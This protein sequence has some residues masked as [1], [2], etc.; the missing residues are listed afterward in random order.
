[1]ILKLQI[2]SLI[3][4]SIIILMGEFIGVPL[5]FWLAYTSLE[6]GSINQ[7]YAIFGIIGFVINFTKYINLR[8]IKIISFFLMMIPIISRL[9]EI[10][11]EKFNYLAFQ[12]PFLIFTISYL[13]IIFKSSK[14]KMFKSKSN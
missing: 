10:P 6:F 11:I 4:Y 14:I 13:L 2:I 3:S 9:I 5:L 8:F 1:M 7:L 12:I